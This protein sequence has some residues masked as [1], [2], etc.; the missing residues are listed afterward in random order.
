MHQ[1][2]SRAVFSTQKNDTGQTL[3]IL[4]SQTASLCV[5]KF[6]HRAPKLQSPTCTSPASF[7]QGIML[8]P[9]VPSTPPSK[10]Q[11]ADHILGYPITN[12]A[13][14]SKQ[15]GRVTT[16]KGKTWRLVGQTTAAK[17]NRDIS[18]AGSVGSASLFVYKCAVQRR[19]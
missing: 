9:L 8:C 14:H 4:L 3:S 10:P 16:P 1:R 19:M 13:L 6:R 12:S 2:G 7:R 11:E 5:S 17:R 18:T 15:R